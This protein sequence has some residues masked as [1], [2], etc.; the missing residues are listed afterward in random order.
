MNKNINENKSVSKHS[1]ITQEI[2]IFRY[3]V[4]DLFPYI[5]Y[6]TVYDFDKTGS[7]L[8]IVLHPFFFFFTLNALKLT[9][10][11]EVQNKELPKLITKDP[12]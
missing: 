5:T 10:I 4:F 7:L 2:T 8:Y 9:E 3:L 12:P 11:L 1:P 6:I